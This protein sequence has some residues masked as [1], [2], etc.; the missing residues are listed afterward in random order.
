M[1]NHETTLS[2]KQQKEVSLVEQG[3]KFLLELLRLEVNFEAEKIEYLSS[4]DFTIEQLFGLFSVQFTQKLS[5]TTLHEKLKDFGI[6]QKIDAHLLLNRYDAD[7]DGSLTFWE[8]AN[9]LLPVDDV[10]R[11]EMLGREPIHTAVTPYGC[12]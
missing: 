11:Q 9:I 7:E 3:R 6:V 4:H 8:F 2:T 10:L 1:G 5:L 12:D